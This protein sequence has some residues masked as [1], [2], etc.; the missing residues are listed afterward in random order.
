MSQFIPLNKKNGGCPVCGDTSGGCRGFQDSN[1]ILCMKSDGDVPGW[2]TSSKPKSGLWKKY[3]PEKTNWQNKNYSKNDRVIHTQRVTSQEKQ[4]PK[5]KAPEILS[6]DQRDKEYKKAFSQ[7]SLDDASHSDLIGR[8]LSDEFIKGFNFKSVGDSRQNKTRFSQSVNKNLP[9]VTYDGRSIYCGAGEDGYIIPAL[10]ADGRMVGFQK[11]ILG[12]K[13]GNKYK[14]AS[15]SKTKEFDELPLQ[16]AIVNHEPGQILYVSEAILKSLIAS[17]RFG[18]NVIGASGGMF[19]ASKKT[20]I[21][22]VN[23][24]K[25]SQIV[26]CPDAATK[27]NPNVLR[28]YRKLNHLVKALGYSLMALDWGQGFSKEFKD[29]DEIESIDDAKVIAYSSWDC[30]ADF[31]AYQDTQNLD[32]NDWKNKKTIYSHSAWMGY[33]KYTPDI[34]INVEKCPDIFVD[35]KNKNKAVGFPDYGQ[36][37]GLKLHTGQGKTTGIVRQLMNKYEGMGA[38][39]LPSRNSLGEQ[40]I[41]DCDAY[42]DEHE[43]SNQNRFYMLKDVAGVKGYSFTSDLESRLVLCPDSLDK[44]QPKDFDGRVLILDECESEMHHTLG[45]ETLGERQQHIIEL[46]RELLQ[47]CHC[48][49]IADANLTDATVDCIEEISGKSITKIYNNKLPARPKVNFYDGVGSHSQKLLA[50]VFKEDFPWI[51]SDS[52]NECESIAQCGLRHDKNYLRIDSETINDSDNPDQLKWIR[53]FLSNPEV[54]DLPDFPYDGII[55]SPC[56]ESGLSSVSKRFTGVYEFIKHLES[57]YSSQ[58]IMRAR[59]IDCPRHLAIV[60]YVSSRDYDSNLNSAFDRQLLNNLAETY[61]L[62]MQQFQDDL[63]GQRDILVERLKHLV[64]GTFDSPETKLFM[65]YQAIKNYERQHLK[66]CLLEVLQNSGFEIVYAELPDEKVKGYRQD[67][68]DVKEA[69]SEA[70]YQAPPITQEAYESLCK[71]SDLDKKERAKKEKYRLIQTLPGID[72]ND[73]ETGEIYWSTSLITHIKFKHPLSLQQAELRTLTGIP[74]L[75]KKRSAKGWEKVLN[76]KNKPKFLGNF[77]D[78]HPMVSTL[79]RLGIPELLASYVEKETE[80]HHESPEIVSLWQR[81]DKKAAL[82]TKVDRGASPTTLIKRLATK[83]GYKPFESSQDEERRYFKLS[84]EFADGFGAVI[85][86][87]VKNGLTTQLE[88]WTENHKTDQDIREENCINGCQNSQTRQGENQPEQ[89]SFTHPPESLNDNQAVGFRD[90]RKCFIDHNKQINNDNNLPHGHNNYHSSTAVVDITPNSS[91]PSQNQSEI[92]TQITHKLSDEYKPCYP[93]P[94]WIGAEIYYEGVKYTAK[95]F[96]GVSLLF[97][98]AEDYWSISYNFVNGMV[99]IYKE[100][101]NS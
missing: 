60:E 36:G 50:Q 101:N 37:I 42:C 92:Y 14:W 86:K 8:G 54:V 76:L 33:K 96:I 99:R 13:E 63:P 46:K 28:E 23:I 7:M 1:E 48:I 91:V 85:F 11:R 77:R 71:R 35:T 90:D 66:E 22:A 17:V 97:V 59:N 93:L 65:K 81:W 30:L 58:M 61:R 5:A 6:A 26:L 12:I 10:D 78:K 4:E 2:S 3:W 98:N 74:E 40:F 94:N 62:G 68:R 49:I 18:I 43:L 19:D 44:F 73:E 29:I 39:Y 47:R 27:S 16:H 88:K 57:M 21:H 31:D 56:I 25:P 15:N 84:D 38:I 51:M 45:G 53:A 75:A 24:L 9:G 95:R 79:I 69:K 87:Y 70:I 52:Q 64:E 67:K 82:L 34:S 41:K 20:F 80:Y 83:L 100:F 72:C 32:P 89:V 55:S